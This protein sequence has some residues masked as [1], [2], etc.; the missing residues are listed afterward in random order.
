MPPVITLLKDAVPPE[1]IVMPAPPTATV[2]SAATVRVAVGNE[3]QPLEV[4]V[5]VKVAVPAPTAVMAPALVMVAT[6][7]LL[8]AQVPPVVGVMVAVPPTQ[9]FVELKVP[10]VGRGVI[11]KVIE[12]LA[13]GQPELLFVL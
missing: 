6:A 10:M 3:T 7:V 12:L 9:I 4:C 2:G 8:D 5:N 13:C 1:Q 11:D